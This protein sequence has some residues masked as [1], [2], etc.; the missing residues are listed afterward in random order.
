M[1]WKIAIASPT[2]ES[3]RA[4]SSGIRD[5]RLAVRKAG[6]THEIIRPEPATSAGRQLRGH[7][8]AAS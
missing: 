7:Q 6:R 3:P 2:P 1:T 4:K 5:A 8:A